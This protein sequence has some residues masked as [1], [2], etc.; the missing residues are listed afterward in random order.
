MESRMA[1]RASFSSVSRTGEREDELLADLAKED[2][3][4]E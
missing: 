3:F 4:R 1:V 2:A